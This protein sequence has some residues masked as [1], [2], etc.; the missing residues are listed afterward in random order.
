MVT[1]INVQVKQTSST[2]SEGFIRQHAVKIDRP[3]AK[4][5]TDEGA[6]GGE[7]LLVS[8]GGCFISNLLAAIRAREAA[9]SNVDITITGTLESAPPR[10]SA[11]QM[12]IAADYD[13]R[14]LMEKLVTISERGCIVANTLK[15]AVD[16]S[17]SVQ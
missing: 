5:G 6:M 11:V 3:E 13:D 1:Q 7:L 2:A 8:L 10:F 4:G 16:L 14:D 9:V 17:I 12:N 15:H